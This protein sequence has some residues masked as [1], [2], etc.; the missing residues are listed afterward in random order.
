MD[1]VRYFASQRQRLKAGHRL[2]VAG[3]LN[4]VTAVRLNAHADLR[5]HAIHPQMEIVNHVPAAFRT[6]FGRDDLVVHVSNSSKQRSQLSQAI[7]ALEK[8]GVLKLVTDVT[9]SIL[10]F[11]GN[12][13]N[14]FYHPRVHGA[15]FIK[16]S[17][18]HDEFHLMEE[19]IHQ[20]GHAAFATLM[21]EPTRFLR[22]PPQQCIKHLTSEREDDR[23]V[24]VALHGLITEALV[25]ETLQRIYSK[26]TSRVERHQLVGRLAFAT[27]K[28]AADLRAFIECA[29]ILGA[30][31]L[32]LLKAMANTYDNV[33]R[34]HGAVLR[35]VNLSGQ[36]YVFSRNRYLA[37]NP[38][39]PFL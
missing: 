25:T 22:V 3:S 23:S 11:H 6:L 18:S 24:L 1:V 20:A 26:A 8:A 33:W 34:R 14:S 37:T 38:I 30:E 15:I 19:I 5:V 9:S 39:D 32:V 7:A 29:G 17:R 28:L 13:K 31:G 10:L 16:F 27:S 36:P 21:L 2:L 35:R 4:A 12:R